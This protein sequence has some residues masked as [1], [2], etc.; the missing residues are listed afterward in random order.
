MPGISTS[1]SITIVIANEA[2]AVRRKKFTGTR[3]ATQQA[4]RPSTVHITWRPKIAQGEPS[5][6]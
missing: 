2:K 1:T 6:S 5:S 4:N 3:S